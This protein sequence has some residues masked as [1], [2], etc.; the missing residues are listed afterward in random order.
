M[1]N[2]LLTGLAAFAFVSSITPGPNNL[3]LMSSGANFGFK[4]TIPH[5]L[6]VSIGF[7]LMI[8][9]VGMGLMQLFDRFPVSYGILKVA[10]IIYMLYLA[11][12]IA[13]SHNSTER[14]K[15]KIKPL[16][17]I[18]AAVFQ[19]VNPKAWTMALT[20]ISI[21]APSNSYAAI[22]LVAILFGLINLPCIGSWIF[23]GQRVQLLLAEKQHLKVF[24]ITMATLLILSLYPVL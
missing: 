16:T 9:L 8:V 1:D 17:F 6:G 21:Y 13:G 14:T 12:K 23:L 3:M 19:W 10:S 2:E 7:T 5:F 4:Q 18:Q 20:A 15:A 22:L 11:F 24:N